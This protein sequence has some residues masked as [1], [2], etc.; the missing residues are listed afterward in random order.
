MGSSPVKDSPNDES[1]V[2]EYNMINLDNDDF[3]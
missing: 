3:F 1:K 2:F